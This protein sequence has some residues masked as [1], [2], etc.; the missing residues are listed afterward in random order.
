MLGYVRQ[1]MNGI[2]NYLVKHGEGRLLEMVQRER[3]RLQPKQVL[4]LDAV[5]EASLQQLVIKP[6][7]ATLY[8]RL[9]SHLEPSVQCLSRA[10]STPSAELGLCA[11]RPPLPPAT[12]ARI[13]RHLEEM[14]ETYSPIRKLEHLLQCVAQIAQA[15]DQKD[16]DRA[17]P[18]HSGCPGEDDL[19]PGLVYAIAHSGLAGAEL[20][21]EYMLG[22]LHPHMLGGD[23]AYY[24]CLLSGAVQVL[25]ALGDPTRGLC[26]PHPLSATYLSVLIPDEVTSSLS[27][28]SVAVP[29][30][31][32]SR[33]V[34]R[35]L[36]HCLGVTEPDQYGLF[37]IRQDGLGEV[38][39]LPA[40]C[41]QAL[42]ASLLRQGESPLFAY[43][44]CEAK[45]VWPPSAHHH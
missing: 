32:S 7:R 21:L 41:P 28:Q 3:T 11:D 8:H 1:F 12:L 39:L 44:R 34:C 43:K 38:A 29:L 26:Q 19:L 35:M 13:K 20:E 45:F 27:S 10:L 17:R 2:K 4:N 31:M 36:A 24:L 33:D 16:P 9:A 18:L 42:R 30:R 25:K 6:L 22:L 14:Q 15:G 40:E 23:S 5:L 37:R